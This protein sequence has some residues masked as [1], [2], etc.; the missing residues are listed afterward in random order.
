MVAGLRRDSPA[1]PEP[2]PEPKEAA[3]KS[4]SPKTNLKPE[5]KA[6]D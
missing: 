2:K 5:P 6:K 1:Q 4:V 3:N